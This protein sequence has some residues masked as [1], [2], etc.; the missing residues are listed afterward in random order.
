MKYKSKLFEM[1]KRF[2]AEV[3]KQ[4]RKSI[5]TLSSSWGGEYVTSELL[6]YVEENEI[7][8]QWTPPE[9]PQYNGVLEKKNWIFLDIV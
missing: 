8:L 1:F 2:H 9:T 5:K 4:T 3:E 7:L 6:I